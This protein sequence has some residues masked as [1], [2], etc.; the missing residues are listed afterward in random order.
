MNL[1]DFPRAALAH[2]PTPLE[3]M[4]R[5][6][7]ELGGPRLFVKR[8]D[9]TGLALGGNKTRKLEFLMAE[10]LAAGADSVITAGGVQSNHVRQ[11]AA[12]AAKLGL[13]AHLVLTR[14]V[15]QDAAR[16]HDGYDRTGNILLDRLLG[17]EIRILPAGGDRAAAMDA[18]AASLRAAG[19]RPYVIPLGGSNATGALGYALCARELLAQAEALC[20]G[21][22]AI[23]LASSSGGSQAGLIAGLAA[24][25]DPARV[26]GIEVDGNRETVAEA[27]RKVAA[28]AAQ[29]LGLDAGEVVA[30]V[31]VVA[32]YGGPGYGLPTPEMRRAVELAARC[33]GLLLD[34]VYSG[35]AM[36]G[37]IGL[38][39]ERR[40]AADDRV[41]FLHSGG[42]PALFAYRSVFEG[43]AAVT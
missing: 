15:P 9:C 26:I 21:L 4:E 5:L 17:A 3:S 40:F 41:V 14:N 18:L 20:G 25:G 33:E 10:A 11:T 27:V 43:S 32:G 13:A 12:A 24:L 34:P 1:D 31:E 7:A 16:E 28:A 37:L 39:A 30:R 38:I 8:D 22:D 2:L 36:A 42:T 6:S 29:R 35:K 23:V 19:G